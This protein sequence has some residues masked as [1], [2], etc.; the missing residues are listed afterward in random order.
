MVVVDERYVAKGILGVEDRRLLGLSH[1]AAHVVEHQHAAI[2]GR[3]P[4]ALCVLDL[5]QANGG[6]HAHRRRLCHGPQDAPAA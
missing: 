2:H 4:C 6:A 5:V 3:H 1:D